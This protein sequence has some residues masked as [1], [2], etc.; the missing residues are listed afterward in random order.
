[1]K[2]IKQKDGKKT[3]KQNCGFYSEWFC[4]TQEK[5]DIIRCTHTYIPLRVY[6]TDTTENIIIHLIMDNYAHAFYRYPFRLGSVPNSFRLQFI[7]T[8]FPLH[9]VHVFAPAPAL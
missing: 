3:T 5:T 8:F 6:K 9:S 1:M 7:E 4:L 2:T